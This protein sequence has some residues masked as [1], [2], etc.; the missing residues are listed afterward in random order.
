MSVKFCD[1]NLT[2]KI[3]LWKIFH[4]YVLEHK[5]FSL[6]FKNKLISF[7][8]KI[9]FEDDTHSQHWFIYQW[10]GVFRIDKTQSVFLQQNFIQISHFESFDNN[11][12]S[13]DQHYFR[14][15]FNFEK[16]IFIS[17]KKFF[18]LIFFSLKY[19]RKLNNLV[20]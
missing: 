19:F 12:H 10:R 3:S 8:F 7:W 16:K 9:Y 13:Y 5:Y 15:L 2:W 4:F 11:V 17:L 14:C 18:S 1:E 20:V 6:N